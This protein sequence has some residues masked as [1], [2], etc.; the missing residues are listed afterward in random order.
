VRNRTNRLLSLD[1]PRRATKARDAEAVEAADCKPALTRC[2]CVARKRTSFKRGAVN[3]WPPERQ[4]GR[5]LHFPFFEGPSF[6]SRMAHL[7]CADRGATPRG[8]TFFI[9]HEEDSNPP[10]SG[11]GNTRGSTEVPDHFQFRQSVGSD[12][13]RWYRRETGATPVGGSVLP[14]S[15]TARAPGS[16]PGG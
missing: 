11:R 6:N 15:S 2:K 16:D 9:G 12:A 7:Q 5:A 10:R 13:R 8:S 14:C 4:S 1:A 3:A